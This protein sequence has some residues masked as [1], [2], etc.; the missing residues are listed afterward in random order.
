MHR[1]PSSTRT[2]RTAVLTAVA[3]LLISTSVNA[4]Q[5]RVS[6]GNFAF[7]PSTVTVNLGDHVV[8]VWTGGSHSVTSGTDGSKTGDGI[9]NSTEQTANAAGG[10]N[11]AFSWKSDRTGAVPYYCI[12][13]FP[14]MTGSI[15]VLAGSGAAVADF[16][17]TEVLYSSGSADLIE[18]T[19]MGTA[20]GDLG[21]YRIAI[22][23]DVEGL[24][25]ASVNVA[26]G[27]IVIL[28]PNASGTN[29]T[30]NVFVPALNSL[31]D[32]AGSVALYVPSTI[33]GHTALTDA[34]QIVDFVQYGAG[35]Q[36]NEAAAV[37]A[38]F[39]TS[40][41]FVPTVGV[42]GR[43]IEFCGNR[44]D[45]GAAQWSEIDPPNFGNDGNCITPTQTATWGRVKTLYR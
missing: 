9:F 19:N 31:A 23:G 38:G 30:S 7:N 27:G 44:S 12:P 4:G 14:D 33:S 43:S 8:W 18:I 39:W 22:S 17:I 20:A 41:Q 25:I 1:R 2:S 45:H 13:H 3:V 36:A 34:T 21:R 15:T 29:S 26:P 32:A 42:A 16:R 6:V 5:V 11:T 24:P 37:T 40:G 10:A 28:H 35:G